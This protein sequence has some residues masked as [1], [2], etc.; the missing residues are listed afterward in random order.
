MGFISSAIFDGPHIDPIV[1][2]VRSNPLD[3]DDAFLE[4]YRRDQSVI[5]PLDV[6]NDAV[7]AENARR[8]VQT[9]NVCRANPPSPSHF[10]EPRIKSR[11]ERLMITMPHLSLDE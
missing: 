2:A 3:P 6:E 8:C 11:F 7:G 9:L 10:I 4:V 5:V 1:I